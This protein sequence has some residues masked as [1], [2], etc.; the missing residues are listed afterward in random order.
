M[1][2]SAE[3]KILSPEDNVGPNRDDI[4]HVL[5]MVIVVDLVSISSSLNRS[6]QQFKGVP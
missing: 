3:K 1:V 4:D 6:V 2:L 5:V